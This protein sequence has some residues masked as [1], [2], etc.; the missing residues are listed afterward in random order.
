MG[1]TRE[2][3][4]ERLVRWQAQLAEVERRSAM[5]DLAD[6]LGEAARSAALAERSRA[7]ADGAA[8]SE[9]ATL[10]AALTQRAAFAG[11]LTKLAGDADASRADAQAQVAWQAGVLGR[12]Q[13]RA[14]RL[15]ERAEAAARAIA[16]QRERADEIVAGSAR[17][18]S[19]AHP[20]QE[21]AQAAR[22]RAATFPVKG[23]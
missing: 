10:A 6:A 20:V 5:R 7:L 9:G 23:H 15:S 12:A 13:D 3:R 8:M 2:Q 19:L 17:P 16:R 21:P 4:R 14:Q 18:R 1:L 22:E 11:A